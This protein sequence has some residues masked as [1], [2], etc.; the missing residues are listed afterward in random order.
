MPDAPRGGYQARVMVSIASYF[1]SSRLDV[2]HN[3]PHIDIHLIPSDIG[4]TFG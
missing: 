3:S 1:L 4:R 2:L